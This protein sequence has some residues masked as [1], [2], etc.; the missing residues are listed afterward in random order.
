MSRVIDCPCGHRLEAEN[1]D[2]LFHAA[3]RHVAEHHPEMQRSDEQLR[4]TIRERARD[5]APATR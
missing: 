4:A 3:Q 2:E 5:A 1:D